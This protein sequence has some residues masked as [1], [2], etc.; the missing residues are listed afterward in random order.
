VSDNHDPEGLGRV[1]V[2]L[3]WAPDAGGIV[4]IEKGQ[5]Y[6]AWARMA[7]LAAGKNRGSWFLP[8]IGD[9]VL[10][11]FEAG[12][13]SRPVVVGALW[14]GVDTPPVAAGIGNEIK[15]LRTRSGS[16]IRFNDEAG[17]ETIDIRTAA[18]QSV[19]LTNEGGGSARIADGNS[20]TVTLTAAGITVQT[21][22]TVAVKA[23]TITLEAA[24]VKL[25]SAMVTCDG[26]LKSD[27]VI[28]NTVVASTYTPGAG[29]IW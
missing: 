5:G 28:T 15:V 20:S 17:H 4:G 16:E 10:V 11:T 22:S 13:P 26:V 1:H 29:N 8:D 14:N 3:P 24:A 12:H 9:E 7:T 21:S 23:S 6:G 27:T 25:K 2:V 19:R 18:G